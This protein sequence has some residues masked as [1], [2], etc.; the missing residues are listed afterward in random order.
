MA[1]KDTILQMRVTPDF[2]KRLRRLAKRESK[3]ISAIV[4]ELIEIGID[5]RL[6]ELEILDIIKKR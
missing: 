4:R 3:T 2:K 6:E 5:D 1:A